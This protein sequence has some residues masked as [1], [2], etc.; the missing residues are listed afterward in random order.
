MPNSA[1][2]FFL[3]NKLCDHALLQQ[4]AISEVLG[5]SNP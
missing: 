4:R 2:P 3:A 5:A 1:L